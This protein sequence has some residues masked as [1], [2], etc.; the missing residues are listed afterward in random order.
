VVFI[1]VQ[2]RVMKV[3]VSLALYKHFNAASVANMKSKELAL[4]L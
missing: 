4:N 2:K 3:L 1:P